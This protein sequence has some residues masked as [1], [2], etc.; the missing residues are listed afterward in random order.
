MAGK[1][2]CEVCGYTNDAEDEWCI[3]CYQDRADVEI[4]APVDNF[5]YPWLKPAPK[6]E[7]EE[8]EDDY[9]Y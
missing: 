8:E 6:E 4:K 5:P 9:D 3:Q 7:D 2:E 1:W